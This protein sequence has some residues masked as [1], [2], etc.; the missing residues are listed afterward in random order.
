MGFHGLWQGKLY[1]FC[2]PFGGNKG[3]TK[4]VTPLVEQINLRELP[5]W[6]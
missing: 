5:I 6:K 4:I 2:Y 3:V 1:N